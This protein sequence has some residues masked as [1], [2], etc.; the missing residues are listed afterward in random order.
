MQEKLERF[1]EQIDAN[2]NVHRAYDFAYRWRRKLATAAVAMVAAWMAFH[3]IF[4]ANGMVVYQSKKAEY[5]QRQIDVESLQK[6]NDRLNK[7]VEALRT[8]SRAIEKAAR[9]EFGYARP[10]EV[11]YLLPRAQQTVPANASAKLK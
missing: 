7:A 1:V 4:G 10:G 2:E 11:I 5:H 9:E 6:E 3:V 8:D